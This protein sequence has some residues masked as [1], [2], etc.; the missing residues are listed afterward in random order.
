MGVI[1]EFVDATAQLLQRPACRSGGFTT[2]VR[3]RSILC[4]RFVGA[5]AVLAG[6][7]S[8]YTIFVGGVGPLHWQLELASGTMHRRCQSVRGFKFRRYS[9]CQVQF[10]PEHFS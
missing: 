9:G 3:L 1:E 7:V 6:V 2:T 8:C 4:G 5:R 10:E